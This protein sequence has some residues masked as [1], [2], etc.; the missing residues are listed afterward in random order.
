MLLYF[1]I[2]ILIIKFFNILAKQNFNI[3]EDNDFCFLYNPEFFL[4]N[5]FN[6]YNS[7]FNVDK[8]INYK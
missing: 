3:N 7:Y 4:I 1:H 8:K 5:E 2:I 6:N